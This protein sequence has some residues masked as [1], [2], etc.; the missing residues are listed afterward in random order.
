[1]YKY[2]YLY[3]YIYIYIYIY[4]HGSSGYMEAQEPQE[5][6][7]EEPNVHPTVAPTLPLCCSYSASLLQLSYSASLLH[8]SY[9]ASLLQ[10]L[11]LLVAATLPLCCTYAA[12]VNRICL[13]MCFKQDTFL[14]RHRTAACRRL[15]HYLFVHILV[16]KVRSSST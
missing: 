9:S 8:L 7:V 10:L 1:M 14:T 4:K 16:L 12:F 13:D 15:T 5:A 2:V 11:C 6:D 3:I